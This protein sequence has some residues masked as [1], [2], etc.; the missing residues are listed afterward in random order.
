MRWLVFAS[1]FAFFAA[2]SC[3][4]P[5]VE[6]SQLPEFFRTHPRCLGDT[7]NV[8]KLFRC[9]SPS[10]DVALVPNWL[11]GLDPASD[12]GDDKPKAY[13]HVIRLR[14]GY[15]PL[16]FRE[17]STGEVCAPNYSKMRVLSRD[18]ETGE[19]HIPVT[20]SGRHGELVWHLQGEFDRYLGLRWI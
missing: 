5:P 7:S 10:E 2:T 12:G 16:L 8:V 17:L 11:Y 14:H 6:E 18:D 4:H 20:C 15:I 3:S 13:I 19:L 9:L 1:M